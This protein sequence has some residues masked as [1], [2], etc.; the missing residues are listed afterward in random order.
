MKNSWKYLSIAFLAILSF[1]S[2][3]KDTVTVNT[4]ETITIPTE[5]ADLGSYWGN[6]AKEVT[7]VLVNTQGGPVPEL[8]DNEMR[9][10]LG[11]V[12]NDK[13]KDL[14]VFN[15]HQAQTKNPETFQN[16]ITFEEA[17]TFDQES[18][19]NLAK[20]IKYFKEQGKKVHVL[21]IS[22]G[23]FMTQEL[24]NTEGA[25]IADDYLIMVGRLDM[26]EV[27]WK[28]FSEGNIGG[29]EEGLTPFAEELTGE[30]IEKNMSRLAAGLGHKRYTELLANTDLSKVTFVYGDLEEQ[31][32]RLN[33]TEI[34]FLTA[35]GATVVRVPNADHSGAIDG[36]NAQFGDAFELN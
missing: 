11:L 4:P 17:K 27:I 9:D 22:F 36:I 21:G 20:V 6:T 32:G 31:V 5:I 18:V 2:C 14:F 34:D 1:T 25:S 10:I 3:K 29:F 15:V 28:S 16:A 24:L 33:Q 35:K 8:L 26:P 12:D 13:T 7:D 23:A 30:P 19:A